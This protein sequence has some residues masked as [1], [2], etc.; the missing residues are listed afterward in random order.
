LNRGDEPDATRQPSAIVYLGV[1]SN[2][3]PARNLPHALQLLLKRGQRVTA[4]STVWRTP[5][6][7]RPEQDDYCNCVWR[8]ETRLGPRVLRDSQL[9]PLE[10]E[11]GRIRGTDRYAAR[12]LD[13]DILLHGELVLNEPD[14]QVP[15]P[16]IGRRAFLALG[17]QELA[18][19]LP[20]LQDK[21][22]QTF[23]TDAASAMVTMAATTEIL[24]AIIRDWPG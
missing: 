9:R 16:D 12:P 20:I 8:L 24:R 18:P 13:L 19:E 1:G 21:A 6:I 17:L 4:T 22:I 7:G 5:A 3:S 23:M 2:I 15:D 14:L 10:V 11:L